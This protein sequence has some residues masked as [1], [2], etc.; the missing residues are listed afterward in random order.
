MPTGD[1]EPFIFVGP[2]SIG[3]RPY[4]R[5]VRLSETPEQQGRRLAEQTLAKCDGLDIGDFNISKMKNGNFWIETP[6]GEGME[7]QADELV[8][9]IAEFYKAKL[10]RGTHYANNG[11][12]ERNDSQG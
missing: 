10:I 12:S 2:V 3:Q 7:A 11:I 1:P 8:Q 4:G 9:A 5:I 6:T